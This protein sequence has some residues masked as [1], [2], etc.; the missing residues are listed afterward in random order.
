MINW[1][2]VSPDWTLG[3]AAQALWI[4]AGVL[5]GIVVLALL[6]AVVSAI[7]AELDS[8]TFRQ[9]GQARNRRPEEA[10]KPALIPAAEF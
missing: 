2:E 10:S 5:A 6:F 4:V 1:I 7:R 9:L 3:M 8:S